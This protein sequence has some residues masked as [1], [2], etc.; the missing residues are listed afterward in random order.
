VLLRET[1]CLL[2]TSAEGE[3]LAKD[4]LMGERDR[5]WVFLRVASRCNALKESSRG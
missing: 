1:L 3:P 2:G 5:E 4:F